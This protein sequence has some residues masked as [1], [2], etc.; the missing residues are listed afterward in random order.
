MQDLTLLHG[1]EVIP[2]DSL[3]DIMYIAET[4]LRATLCITKGHSLWNIKIAEAYNL[5]GLKIP[6]ISFKNSKNFLDD[7]FNIPKHISTHK[8]VFSIQEHQK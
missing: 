3:C 7:P 1:T 8:S 5:S 4:N 2:K 6:R